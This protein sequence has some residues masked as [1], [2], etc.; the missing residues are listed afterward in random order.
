MQDRKLTPEQTDPAVRGTQYPVPSTQYAVS[1]TQY[2]VPRG[3]CDSTSRNATEDEKPTLK[4]GIFQA[5][6]LAVIMFSS[7]GLYL[8]ILKWRGPDG[9]DRRTHL[10]WDDYFPFEPGWVWA[11]LLPY[12][13]G[14][15]IVGMLTVQTFH[16]FVSRGLVIV[17]L[18]LSIFIVYPTQTAP[19]EAANLDD[20]P[21][22]R[23]Y[24]F[25]IETDDPP[26]NAAPSLHVS[27]TCLLA[28]ALLRD[29]PRWWPLSC[30]GV[31]VVWLSTL[32]TRQ[33][34]LIDVGTGVLL[35]CAV[36]VCWPQR[37]RSPAS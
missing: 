35:A 15:M 25:M 8:T 37:V 18:S 3:T 12:L 6:V 23:L 19:R 5:L 26:A 16:W 7:L 1:S 20:G 10:P 21:T 2:A 29:F 36:V 13:F 34:H 33:H 24:N 27:L 30:L 17:A 28:L 9:A 4:R 14:P 22:A 32:L 11:Y 31:A